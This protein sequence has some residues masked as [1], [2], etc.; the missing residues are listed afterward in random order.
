MSAN[1]PKEYDA[2]LGG[3]NF[4]PINAAILGGI[5]GVKHRLAS[6]SVE[7]RRAAITEALNYGEEGL[8]AAIAVF[9]DADEQVRAIAAAVFGAQEQ[10]ILLKKGAAIR[11]KWRVQN[12]LLLSGFVDLSWGDFSGFDLAK[13]NLRDSNLAGANFASSNLRGAKIFQSNLE[14][15]NLRNAD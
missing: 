15:T 14:L 12:L 8:E 2:V 3:Q 11:N 13:A 1:E 6:P 7:A 4:P 5:A 10:L 9:D